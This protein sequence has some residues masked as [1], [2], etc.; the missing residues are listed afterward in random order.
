[1][2]DDERTGRALQRATIAWNV[3]EVGITIGLGIVAGSLALVAFGLDSLIEVFAS[4]V[5]IWHMTTAH[6]DR[7]A[8]DR[9]AA[10]L[11][12][13]AFAALAIYLVIASLRALW[14]RAE[15]ESSPLGIA[16]LALT[17]VVMFTLAVHKKRVGERLDSAPFVAEARMTLLDG[18][19]ATAILA[20]LIV[21]SLF[22]W[23]WADAVA[24]ITIGGVAA[25]EA[26]ELAHRPG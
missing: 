13:A 17:A 26:V 1:M 10:R 14:V 8:G 5:V 23:W 11:V 2:A 25:H 19:L 22:G 18:W 9:R 20:A 12:A 7:Q 4:L 21:N 6:P 16:Y 15:P 3:L 24:A